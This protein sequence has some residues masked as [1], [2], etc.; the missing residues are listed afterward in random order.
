MW[1]LFFPVY[2]VFTKTHPSNF[3]TFYFQRHSHR[4]VSSLLS[5]FNYPHGKPFVNIN[6]LCRLHIKI[7]KLWNVTSTAFLR[8]ETLRD[9]VS[10]AQFRPPDFIG[11]NTPNASSD[12]MVKTESESSYSIV[13][14]ST[15]TDD[16]HQPMI[17]LS[18]IVMRNRLS[19]GVPHQFY[20][21]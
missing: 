20:Y 7:R 11:S 21:W 2:S 17:Y 4:T 13:I 1:N 8:R 19:A 3:Y 9:C 14:L 6:Y 12:F 16:K 10:S 15:T 18:V 5:F